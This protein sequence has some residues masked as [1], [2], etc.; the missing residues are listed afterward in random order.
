[1]AP[2][3]AWL[4]LASAG[5]R[6]S[7][8]MLALA[9]VLGLVVLERLLLGS[10]VVSRAVLNHVPHYIGGESAMGYYIRGPFWATQ[11]WLGML[12]GLGFAAAAIT[13][14]VY[15]RRYRFEI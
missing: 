11:D 10:N 4:M 14:A 3:Y 7:P 6:R 12:L 9:P 8:F 5:A 1:V 15:L 2:A 13:G